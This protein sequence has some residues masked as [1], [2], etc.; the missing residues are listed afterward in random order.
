MNNNEK[1]NGLDE[2]ESIADNSVA[3]AGCDSFSIGETEN[4]DQELAQQIEMRIGAPP[5]TSNPTNLTS[6]EDS[7]DDPPGWPGF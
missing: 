1:D 7:D 5:A 4:N 3:P 2:I 6:V